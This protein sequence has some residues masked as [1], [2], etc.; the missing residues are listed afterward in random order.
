MIQKASKQIWFKLLVAA[1]ALTVPAIIAASLGNA[2]EGHH[3]EGIP[4]I[5]AL[6][7]VN[8]L[9]YAGLIVYFGRDPIATFYKNR[10]AKF[11]AAQKRADAARAEA[12]AKRAD[13]QARLAKLEANRDQSIQDARKDAAALRAQI[14]DEAKAL[15]E[16][17]RLEAER[18]AQVEIQRAKAALREDLLNQSIHMAQ[19]ILTDKMQDQ[20]QKRLQDEFVAK[21]QSGKG[22]A[23]TT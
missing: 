11:F 23:V 6:Q 2:S 3:S 13:V 8:F 15:S 14:V 5:V 18:T 7:I 10:Q 20:D 22:Q 9:I 19:R 17:L 21:I 12:Q 1:V 16:K 4:T